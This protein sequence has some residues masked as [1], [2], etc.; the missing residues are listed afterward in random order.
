MPV[1]AAVMKEEPRKSSKRKSKTKHGGKASH[2]CLKLLPINTE[3]TIDGDKT[4]H[5]FA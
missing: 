5:L 1:T 4:V 2:S 3:C